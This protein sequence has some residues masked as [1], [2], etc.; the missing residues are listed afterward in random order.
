[1][2]KEITIVDISEDDARKG[3]KDAGMPDWMIEAILELAGLIRNGYMST[4]T[5]TVEDI[6]GQKPG[7]FEKFVGAT[8]QPGNRCKP[9]L[10]SGKLNSKRRG[11]MK[12]RSMFAVICTI[13]GVSVFCFS[14][15]ENE[16]QKLPIAKKQIEGKD[17]EALVKAG[18]RRLPIES[19][20]YIVVHSGNPT[21]TDTIYFDRWGW[22]EAKYSHTVMSMMGI[23]QETNTLTL[24]DGTLMYNIDLDT[25][26][27]TKTEN[28]MFAGLTD[29]SE[30]DMTKMGE[31]TM[32][33]MGGK[34]IGT[35][36]ILDRLA[37]IWEV[38]SLQT[39][40]WIWM[41][42]TLKTVMNMMGIESIST[43]VELKENVKNPEEKM[44]IPADVTFDKNKSPDIQKMLEGLKKGRQ[45]E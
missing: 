27:G 37:D 34:K 43:V 2:G 4:V 14:V 24:L 17:S 45:K 16:G 19:G 11:S 36:K 33:G 12:R 25:R 18:F 26:T 35:E 41:G 28:P 1:M 38:E 21:G 15:T 20:Y 8:L 32:E 31:K 42:I 5:S 30:K 3:M 9:T 23:T 40:T 13:V 29:K 22:L 44:K 7:T 6:T 10:F 39:K